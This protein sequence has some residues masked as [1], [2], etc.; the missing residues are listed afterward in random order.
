VRCSRALGVGLGLL[1]FAELQG[2]ARALDKQ[3]SA[4]AGAV[5]GEEAGFDI[6]GSFL[7]GVSIYNPSYAARPANTGL[8]LFRYA[9]H[10]DIDLIG[11]KLSIPIDVNMFTDR[12]RS[13]M[14]KLIPS[15]GDV[16]TG[17]T[18]T[19]PLGPG[20]LELGARVEH[21]RTLDATTEELRIPPDSQTY[22]DARARYLYSLATTFPKLGEAL[23]NGDV[24]GWLTLGWFAVNPSYAARP[25]NT[26]SALFR[27]AGH[28]ELSVV[29]DKI[30]VGVDGTMF[31]DR[32]N[33]NFVGPTELDLTPELIL[34]APPVELHVAYE[35]DMPIDRGG[36]VQHFVYL[37]A[38][39]E[40]DLAHA[41]TK[42]LETRGHIVSP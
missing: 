38:G 28:V 21:D 30:S 17:V 23:D 37:L 33:A 1:L 18:S 36:L 13:G 39:Y 29:D 5:E 34:R 7:Y 16:I 10:A 12:T 25:D 15:E 22:L 31:T 11:R 9:F 26:G 32:R 27:Y 2:T 24:S 35:R 19:W 42:P 40:F 3:G 4:H 6:E 14:R 41:Q 20:A 8:T